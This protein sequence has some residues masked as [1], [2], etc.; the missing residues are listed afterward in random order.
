MTIIKD[1]ELEIEEEEVIRLL[2]YTTSAC[3]EDI[4]NNIR[5]EI[6][7]HYKYLRPKILWDKIDISELNKN[8]VVLKNGVAFEDKFI[9]AK[10]S[11]CKYVVVLITTIG[12]EIEKVIK[13]A[14]ENCDYVKGMIVE[15]IGIAALNYISKKFWIEMVQKINGSNLGMTSRISPGDTPIPITEQKKVFQCLNAE[16]IGVKLSESNMMFPVKS[17]TAIYGLGE[18]IGIAIAEHVCDECSMKS[19]SFRKDKK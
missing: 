6:Y 12:E 14:F 16:V 15:S 7:S 1:I 17:T 19:C 4:Q 9:S 18:N 5:E 8:R 13:Y 11:N 2:G 10:L 3:S